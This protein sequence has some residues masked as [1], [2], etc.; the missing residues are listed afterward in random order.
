MSFTI[1]VDAYE[2]AWLGIT[3]ED[4]KDA[5]SPLSGLTEKEKKDFTR[6]NVCT[7]RALE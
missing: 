5:R 4:L 2:N 1:D 3:E 6:S 7:K